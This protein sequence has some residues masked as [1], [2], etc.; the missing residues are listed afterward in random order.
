[1]FWKRQTYCH[2]NVSMFSR[3]RYCS[4]NV[5]SIDPPARADPKSSKSC[6]PATSH[7]K[8]SARKGTKPA[9]SQRQPFRRDWSPPPK[10]TPLFNSVGNR[11]FL[12]VPAKALER[13]AIL[14]PTWQ[15]FLFWGSREL[16]LPTRTGRPSGFVRRSVGLKGR[17]Q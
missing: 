6:E 17:G 11:K 15:P 3:K 7:D 16:P 2:V 13:V 9:P 14:G 10:E 8:T 1:M 5:P 12:A 4:R